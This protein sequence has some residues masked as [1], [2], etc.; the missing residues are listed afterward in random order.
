MNRTAQRILMLRAQKRKEL[1]DQQWTRNSAMPEVRESDPEMHEYITT[2]KE[3][4]NTNILLSENEMK[5]WAEKLMNAD[6]TSGAHFSVHEV[7][8]AAERLGIEM[9]GIA[10]IELWIA[11][12]LA[13]S[14]YCQ[15]LTNVIPENRDECAAIYTNMGRSF[16]CDK[17]ASV[18]GDEKLGIYY[19][20]IVE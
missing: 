14:D 9:K 15:A 19:R 16:L 13:Y 2:D 5:F 6:G 1:H 18:A 3:E 7:A 10:M 4:M 8:R 20:C 12:N 17:D 11:S